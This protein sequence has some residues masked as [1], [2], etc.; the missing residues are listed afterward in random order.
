MDAPEEWHHGARP[1]QANPGT[2]FPFATE[3]WR[4][5][6]A[7]SLVEL[8]L[9]AGDERVIGRRARH[10]PLAELARRSGHVV[11]G[12]R[13][14]GNLGQVLRHQHEHQPSAVSITFRG[15]V[16]KNSATGS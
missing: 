9:S 11:Q 5:G 13:S 12:A 3:A 2:E 14:P 6:A 10:E 8:T 7:V 1:S 4:G 16:R 15:L